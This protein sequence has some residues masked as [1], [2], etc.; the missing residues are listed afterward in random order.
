MK[1]AFSILAFLIILL[2]SCTTGEDKAELNKKIKEAE[3]AL[4]DKND[5]FKFDE[6]LAKNAIEA[7]DNY[8][9]AFPKDSLVPAILFKQADLLRALQDYTAAI[10]IYQQFEIDFPN[11]VKAPHCLFLQGF[12]Y[13]N[14]VGDL[15]KAKASYQ[16]FLDKYPTHDLSD[17]VSFSLKNLGKTPEEI[18]QE[19]NKNLKATENDSLI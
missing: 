6:T 3:T 12:V 8:V 18:I 17:D 1:K 4:F 15:E 11:H 14:E 19:F 9:N 5:S 7:Y 13:E 2:V 10:N 16:A